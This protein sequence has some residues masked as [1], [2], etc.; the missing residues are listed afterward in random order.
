MPTI[1]FPRARV[2]LAALALSAAGF[3]GLVGYEGYTSTAVIPIPGD[4]PTIGPG[5]TRREDGSPV[6]SGDTITVP[7]ALA[8]SLREVQGF[9]GAIKRCV[10]VPLHQHEYDAYLQLAYNIGA[11]AFCGST[12][13]RLLN[14]GRYK[15]ACAQILRWRHAAGKDC[16]A[17]GNRCYGL[18]TRR[19]REYTLCLGGSQ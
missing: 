12:L 19:Q 16:S 10:K 14:E 2:V 13:V 3:V 18:Y 5:L 4:V 9:E 17:R 15:E 1:P 6:Q 11:G 7:K 8:L